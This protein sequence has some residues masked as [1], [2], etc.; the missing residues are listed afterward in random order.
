MATPSYLLERLRELAQ[1][2][3][4]LRLVWGWS[5]W[6]A[7][8]V[9]LFIL[10]CGI[11]WLIDLWYDTLVFQPQYL[12]FLLD[13][14]GTDR[15]MLGTDYPFD[16]SETD[17]LGVLAAVAGLSGAER[18]AITGDTAATLFGM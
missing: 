12:R 2:E 4:K 7:V 15:V 5:C 17:P 11:D 10:C 8:V 14:V 9:N 16:M 18:D 6:I 3:R 1:E 13:V